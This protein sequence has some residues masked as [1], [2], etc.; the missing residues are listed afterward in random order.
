M[1]T[2]PNNHSFSSF[3]PLVLI[4]LGVIVL[5]SW[6]LTMALNQHSNGIR[7]SAQ[8]ELQLAQ[9]AQ[10]EDKLKIMMSDLVELSKSDTNAETIVK[11]Y[12]IAFTPPAKATTK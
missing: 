5:F 9:A 3:L 7:I 1:N 4:A 11:R 6:N 2:S 12:K 10:T 8:Q